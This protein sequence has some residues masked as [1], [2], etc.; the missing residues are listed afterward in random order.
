MS[1]DARTI[2][3]TLRENV[4]WSDGVPLKADDFVYSW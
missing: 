3:F 2:T 4:L 1:A